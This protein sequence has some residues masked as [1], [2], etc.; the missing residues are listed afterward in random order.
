MEHTGPHYG[1]KESTLKVHD[2]GCP[3]KPLLGAR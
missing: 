3:G 2:H 1:E